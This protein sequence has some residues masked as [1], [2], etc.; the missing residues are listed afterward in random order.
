MESFS[1][2]DKSLADKGSRFIGMVQYI[3]NG[4]KTQTFIRI[5]VIRFP[6]R[7]SETFCILEARLRNLN[8]GEISMKFLTALLLTLCCFAFTLADTEVT[9]KQIRIYV[10]DRQTLERI[11]STGIDYEGATGKIGAWMEFVASESELQQL[12][13]S[14]IPYD[15]VIDDLAQ[16]YASRLTPGP[17]NALGFGYGSMGGFYTF[18][19]VLQ[20]LD[21]LRLLYPNLITVRD[22]V[23]RTTDNRAIWVAKISDNP[24]LNEPTEPEVLYTALTHAR[25]PQGMMTVLYFMW[26]LLQNYGTNPEATYL[27]NNR[28]MYFIPVVNPDGYVHNQTIRPGGGGMWRENRR[29]NSANCYGV[30]LN[31][32]FGTYQM[33]NS[34]N[35]GSSTAPTCGQGTYRGPSPFSEPETQAIDNFMRTHN[36]KTAFNYHTFGN[37]L[38]YPWGY[39]S[40]ENGDSLIYRD[41][42]YDMQFTNHYTNGTDLQTVN[43]STRGNSD[44]YMYGDTT[45]PITYTMTP[46]VGTSGFWPPT[47]QIFPLAI[48]NLPQN[49]YLAYFA[50]HYPTLRHFEIEDAGGN[51]FLNRGEYFALVTRWK[52]RGLGEATNISITISTNNPYVTFT[53]PS[54]E[55]TIPAQGEQLLSF[56]GRVSPRAVIGVPFQVHFTTTDADGFL[57]RDTI[58][59][60]LGT[61]S[62]VF[63]DS[64]SSGIGNWTTGTGWGTTTNA[65]TP[66]LAFTDSPTGSYSANANNSLTLINQLSLSGYNA[67]EL[68]F[69][70]KWAVEPTWDFATVELSTNNGSTWTTLRSSLSHSGSGRSG[71]QQQSTSWGYDSYTPGLTWVEQRVDLGAYLNRQIRLRF[72]VAADGAD[73]RDG[74]YVD[75]IRVYGYTF[76]AD[77][78]L[79]V[80][81][82][83]F[84]FWGP[85]G[86]LFT[87]TLA[88]YNFTPNAIGITIAETTGTLLANRSP[89]GYA[90]FDIQQVQVRLRA[91][92]EKSTITRDHF[93]NLTTRI[94]DSP[95]DPEVFTTI[96]TD[97]RNEFGFG[98]ADVYR[99]QYQFRSV[100]FIGNFH[101]FRIV[102]A[103][104]PDTNVAGFISIDT[105][106]DFGT[107]AFPTP[108]GVGPTSRDVGSEREVFF[109][110]SGILFD[111]LG[112][113]RIRAGI[114]I[115]TENDS[116]IGIPFLLAI[117]RDSV[118][119][120]TTNGLNLGI[121][122]GWLGDNDR[123][124]NVGV[125]VSRLGQN[126]NPAPDFAPIIGHGTVGSE[127]GI[128]WLTED[129]TSFSIASGDSAMIRI[130][131]L[132]AKPAGTYTAQLRIMP[133]SGNPMSVPVR[134][135]VT[136]PPPPRIVVSRTSFIDTVAVG[137]SVFQNFTISNTGGSQLIYGI[138]DTT[139]TTWLAISPTFGILDSA[140]T[141]LV[142]IAM[143]AT[144]LTPDSTYSAIVFVVSNDPVTGSVPLTVTLRVTHPT[145]VQEIEPIPTHY[146]LLQNYP[147]PFNPSTTIRFEIPA[148]GFVLLSVYNILGQEVATL[149]SERLAAGRYSV[150]FDTDLYNLPSGV[151]FYRLH[152]GT[153]VATKKLV[154][155]R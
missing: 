101:D 78:G 73:Q 130:R 124:M 146:A 5:N 75:D 140:Q 43:Y 138:L 149:I 61:P 69:W 135:N 89:Q 7:L 49:K 137:D 76:N 81:P 95:S 18:A 38:I 139:G 70:T 133:S 19:E 23:G 66:P 99:V 3:K 109:D 147:N 20:Q 4:V 8:V 90:S 125:V 48:E 87:D 129:M 44:D 115:N 151:Y 45:K 155:I 62:V 128:S 110:A 72:R 46:E 24:E 15:V 83:Q 108:Y 93:Q 154:L 104:L 36:I 39:L 27:V 13:A 114:V 153:F 127:T 54:L 141:D 96:V 134:M 145:A 131:A 58:N 122:E 42:T 118:L 10:P 28:Q 123:K 106:Q 35:G 11:W 63:A 132:A 53:R 64:A 112:F 57:K 17:V 152:A 111:S 113:G 59:L 26:W 136:T 50:G 71:S 51:G 68:R 56:N 148:A 85:T 47:S 92:F 80:V 33:W 117:R 143:R 98:A 119:T 37:Y 67:A 25:E 52:N 22:S 2:G 40:R 14:G 34:P 30:D 105:D 60:Y 116:I 142:T 16:F 29:F 6:L 12:E 86:R 31:R 21:S 88:I 150:T 91:A 79:V 94:S 102:L 41:W 9:S 144:G 55:V 32:N 77:T 84:Q 97:E 65:H 103:N 1:C 126:V 74:F 120:I 121:Q 100:P 107:G 82:N